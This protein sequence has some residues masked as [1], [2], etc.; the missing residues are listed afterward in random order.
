[1]STAAFREAILAQPENLE[2]AAQA[3]AD[4]AAGAADEL[5][6]LGSGT[7][8]LSGIGASAHALAPAVAALRAAGRRAFPVPAT[9]L[10][11]AAAARLGDGYV[12]VS[13]SGASAE[14][15]QALEALD[16]APVVAVSARGD[17]PLARAADAWLPL[18]PKPDTPVATLSYTA[19]LQ[20]LGLLAAHLAGPGDGG[21]WSRVPAAVA[22]VLARCA[23]AM[24]ELAEPFAGI[25]A[26]DAAGAGPSAASAGETALLVRE[27]LK[28]PAAGMETREY[29]HGPLEPIG[30]GFG[31]VLF[32]GERERALAQSIAGFGA[33]TLLVSGTDGPP[34]AGVALVSL[35]ELAEMPAAA[36][37][38]VE[39]LPVQ[40]LMERVCTRRGLEIG[41]LTRHQHD[42]KVAA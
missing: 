13:Q 17:S 21:D 35:P 20:T 12:L 14:T 8:V 40:L 15:L 28:L 38:I 1:M 37:P 32:G 25:R 27:A 31:A 24:E 19:T 34:P 30:P 11:D 4:A 42:T 22:A 29:L 10:R 9:E 6:R 26:L 7:I 39:I 16:G 2:Q 23:P 33:E 5:G 41:P 36:A 18:G 3:F